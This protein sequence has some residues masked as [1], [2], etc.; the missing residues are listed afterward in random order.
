MLLSLLQIVVEVGPVTIIGWEQASKVAKG[1]HLIQFN[2]IKLKGDGASSI[3]TTFHGTSK[4]SLNTIATYIWVVVSVIE[5]GGGN[6]EATSG[7]LWVD[8]WVFLKDMDL[9]IPVSVEEMVPETGTAARSV[10]AGWHRTRAYV[11]V[12]WKANLVELTGLRVDILHVPLV[13]RFH[14]MLATSM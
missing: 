7:A 3:G 9:I 1:V 13:R 11:E 10:W 14:A 2:L 5:L 6:V 12:G 8:S 4:A